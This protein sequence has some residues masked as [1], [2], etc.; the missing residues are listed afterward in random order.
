MND[1]PI[2]RCPSCLDRGFV[3]ESCADSQ[4]TQFNHG[5]PFPVVASCRSCQ[6][7]VLHAA[8]F[9][10][11]HMETQHGMNRFLRWQT[12]EPEFARKIRAVIESG[13]PLVRMG[14]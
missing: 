9:W 3:V 13:D 4:R 12:V 1:E 6:R 8:G 10:R 7:G 11:G 5:E 14:V 2:Y